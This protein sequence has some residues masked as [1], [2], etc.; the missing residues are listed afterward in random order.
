[1]LDYARLTPGRGFK[2]L[3]ALLYYTQR[4]LVRPDLRAKIVSRIAAFINWRRPPATVRGPSAVDCTPIVASIK[5]NGW[6]LMPTISP[7]QIDD[8]R[9][10][11]ADKP[12]VLRDRRVTPLNRVPTDCTGADY[13]LKTVLHSPHFFEI[14]NA[15][16]NLEVASQYLGCVPTIS[17]VGIR[18]SLPS[19]GE[20]ATIQKFHRD[21]DDWR[22]LKFFVYLTDVDLTSGP[23]HY[24]AGS[25]LTAG[26]LFARPLEHDDVK[27][28]FGEDRI[29]P[30]TGPAGTAFMVDVNGVHAGPV[31]TSR[32]RLMLT[33]GYS[34]LPVFAMLYEPMSI[35]PRP[36]VEKYINRLFVR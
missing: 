27:R 24:V 30:V 35:E 10:Y 7:E 11:L 20:Q 29:R 34:L 23:H 6:S 19:K 2:P 1:M 17:T 9:R 25:H 3:R 18:W 26:S 4:V 21:P 32:P 28:T 8:I 22:S 31:P 16:A 15:R 33:V 12:V 14:A 5:N 13:D 36:S